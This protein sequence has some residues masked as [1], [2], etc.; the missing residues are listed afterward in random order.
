MAV[1]TVQAEGR[2]VRKWPV[3]TLALGSTVPAHGC[4]FPGPGK[5]FW[6]YKD[7]EQW[8]CGRCSGFS[9]SWSD[10]SNCPDTFPTPPDEPQEFFQPLPR[11]SPPTEKHLLK[12][13]AW[14]PFPV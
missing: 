9:C 14:W 3:G 11:A 1:L 4:L 6:N 8:L 5:P 13:R 2:E 7:K 10:L 12:D